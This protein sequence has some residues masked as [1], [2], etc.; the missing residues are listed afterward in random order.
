MCKSSFKQVFPTCHKHVTEHAWEVKVIQGRGFSLHLLSDN[1]NFLYPFLNS[2]TWN[3]WNTCQIFSL[4]FKHFRYFFFSFFNEIW[5]Y[6]SLA[7]LL[8]NLWC[9][10]NHMM[11]K[12]L[13]SAIAA[14]SHTYFSYLKY[15]K[16]KC[17]QDIQCYGQPSHQNKTLE[18]YIYASHWN[19]DICI[20]HIVDISTFH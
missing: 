10:L 18:V 3:S 2:C 8:L 6:N 12:I 19:A 15:L 11:Q 5:S 16:G 9:L 4:F 20:C 1:F 13:P 17:I 14:D 7:T